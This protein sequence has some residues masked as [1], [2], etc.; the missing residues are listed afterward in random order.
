MLTIPKSFSILSFIW[1]YKMIFAMLGLLATIGVQK[2]MMRGYK[3]DII[4]LEHKVIL[5]RSE[6]DEQNTKIKEEAEKGEQ[7]KNKLDNLQDDLNNTQT[8]NDDLIERLRNEQLENTCEAISKYLRDN[9][10]T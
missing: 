6:I 2:Y 1:K 9:L 10:G 4:E 5:C 7:I 3:L 8:E